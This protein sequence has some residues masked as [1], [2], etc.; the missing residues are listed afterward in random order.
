VATAYCSTA[1]PRAIALSLNR[2]KHP[3]QL[4]SIRFKRHQL[5]VE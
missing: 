4:V 2:A 3:D 5:R 1:P